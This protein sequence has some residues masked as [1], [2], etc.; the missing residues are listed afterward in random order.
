LYVRKGIVIKRL[1]AADAA[2]IKKLAANTNL[3]QHQI[4]ARLDINQGRVSEVLNG[5]R[6]AH[7]SPAR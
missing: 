5:K 3:A 6:F 4:A 1:T 7:V 2:L